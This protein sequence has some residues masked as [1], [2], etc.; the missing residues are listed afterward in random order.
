MTPPAHDPMTLTLGAARALRNGG[1]DAVAALDS[2]LHQA[3]LL[4]PGV[5]HE[6]IRQML[7]RAMSAV[8]A[9][10]VERAVHDHPE[11]RLTRRPGSRLRSR[12]RFGGPV[13]DQLLIRPRY[14]SGRGGAPVRRLDRSGVRAWQGAGNA[15]RGVRAL[16]AA[17]G[18]GDRGV[19]D[20]LAAE[21]GSDDLR[22]GRDGGVQA[23]HD[24]STLIDDMGMPS[25]RQ[26][27]AARPSSRAHARRSRSRRSRTGVGSRAS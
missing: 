10:T 9:E 12:R 8:L 13:R 26:A 2:A 6:D 17:Q 3:L 4:A 18:A 20:L 25:G 16:P 14:R 21:D 22:G 15:V 11:L 1:I 5:E 24:V 27:R 19:T 23:R 7:D